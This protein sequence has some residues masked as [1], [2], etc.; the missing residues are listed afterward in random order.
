MRPYR[1]HTN[2]LSLR[3]SASTYI[4]VRARMASVRCALACACAD[5]LC[6]VVLVVVVVLVLV[7]ILHL[8]LHGV[9]RV[10]GSGTMY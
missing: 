3:A 4:C 8:L 5:H 2:G 9:L 6:A 7:V 10:C 1:A